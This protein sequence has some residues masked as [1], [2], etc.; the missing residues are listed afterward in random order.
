MKTRLLLSMA[1]LSCGA[2]HAADMTPLLNNGPAVSERQE[3]DN[4]AL[5]LLFHRTLFAEG[6][7]QLAAD[8]LMD[9]N[10]IN[11]DV[12]EASGAQGF[13]NF[14]LNPTEYHNPNPTRSSGPHAAPP[15][16]LMRLFVVTDGDLTMM[17][18]PTREPDL[19][20]GAR[21]GSNMFETQHGRVTQWWYSGPTNFDP[22]ARGAAPAG[23]P[24]AA[25]AAGAP[26]PA[27][28]PQTPPDYS[29]WYPQSGTTV[30]SMQA[31]IPQGAVT[32]RAER[33][34]N[35]K[36]VASFFDAFFNQ[37]NYAA[38]QSYLSSDLKSHVIGS[39]QGG[40]FADYARSNRAKVTAEK[41]DSV[42]FLLAEGELVDIGWPVPHNG[43][44]GAWYAQNLLRVKNGKITEWWYSGY[45][46]GSPRLVN[47][48]NALGY[49]PRSAAAGGA[50]GK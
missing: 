40:A 8:L 1:A 35:K 46:N 5:G 11:H 25:A 36:L 16:A 28:M 21:F 20:P 4:K 6:D 18:Y 19:D 48:Y 50:A 29:R 27:P 43:D 30:V 39:S 26:A 17:A 24:P 31:V 23:A 41:T 34:A 37:K 42:L 3:Y 22:A 44:P 45:P 9:P 14:F 15:A 7:P 10:F 32:S 12:E 33:D 47:P 38:A 49:D 13:A 2:A